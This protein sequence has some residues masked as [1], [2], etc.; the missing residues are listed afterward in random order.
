MEKELLSGSW[1]LPEWKL[2]ELLKAD[3]IQEMVAQLEGTSFSPFMKQA[4]TDYDK[5]GVIAIELSLDK[6]LLKM[7]GDISNE[8]T[9]SLGPG[10]RFLIEKEFEARNLK[11]ITKAIAEEMQEE[12]RSV[13]IT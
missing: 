4:M 11:T 10:I 8:N 1:E 3:N 2:N 13:I 5:N 12:A 7:V 9:L 6:Y